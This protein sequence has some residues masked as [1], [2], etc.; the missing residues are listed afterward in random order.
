MSKTLFSFAIFVLF[1]LMSPSLVL[2]LQFKTGCLGV[3]NGVLVVSRGCPLPDIVSRE[4]LWLCCRHGAQRGASRL[5]CMR[6][7]HEQEE[8]LALLVLIVRTPKLARAVQQQLDGHVGKC[9]IGGLP[10]T[11]AS[12]GRGDGC[13]SCTRCF[14]TAPS[15]LAVSVCV[16]TRL[17]S[18][19]MFEGPAESFFVRVPR[20]LCAQARRHIKDRTVC[21]R[22]RCCA[23]VRARDL[24]E[25][26]AGLRVLCSWLVNPCLVVLTCRKTVGR[27]RAFPGFLWPCFAC[28]RIS[29]SE[30]KTSFKFVTGRCLNSRNYRTGLPV[31]HKMENDTQCAESSNY[32]K[33][34]GLRFFFS[35]ESTGVSTHSPCVGR[36]FGF[37]VV[38]QLAAGEGS[39]RA[40][41]VL[42]PRN[43][44]VSK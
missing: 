7:R 19:A 21:C 23:A 42:L 33:A 16:F 25:T 40:S 4:C 6:T 13:R 38:L 44:V 5:G 24:R 32:R 30:T 31:D 28:G 15:V 12:C 3:A 35:N 36:L 18:S 22:D 27:E 11:I 14:R 37:A 9:T 8:R 29:S 34:G 26:S 41:S 1:P 2:R 17:I 39:Q 20:P 43:H 10:K